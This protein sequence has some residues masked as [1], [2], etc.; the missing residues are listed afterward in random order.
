[1]NWDEDLQELKRFYNSQQMSVFN[2]FKFDEK[3]SNI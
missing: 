2:V 3:P 1:M